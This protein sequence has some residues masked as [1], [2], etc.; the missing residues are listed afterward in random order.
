[1]RQSELKAREKF[2]Y[3][4][5][6]IS[7]V[8]ILRFWNLYGDSLLGIQLDQIRAFHVLSSELTMK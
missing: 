8:L 2:K 3:I 7:Y 1:M 4:F 6:S 5:S